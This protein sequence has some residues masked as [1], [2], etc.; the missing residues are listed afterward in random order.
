MDHREL[1]LSIMEAINLNLISSTQHTTESL[2]EP[3]PADQ[4]GG[5]KGEGGDKCTSSRVSVYASPIL[6]DCFKLRASFI[7]LNPPDFFCPSVAA[8]GFTYLILTT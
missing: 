5:G 2:R 8:C 4:G 7:H 3:M 1:I 6:F